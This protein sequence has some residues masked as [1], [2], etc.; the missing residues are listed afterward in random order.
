MKKY[1]KLYDDV[2]NKIKHQILDKQLFPGS[3]IVEER[4]AK[5]EGISRAAVRLVLSRLQEDG[6]VTITPHTGTFV[7]H[8][9]RAEI[10][11]LYDVRLQLEQGVANLAVENITPEAIARMEANYE[12]QQQLIDQYSIKKYARLN[13]DFHWEIIL[14]TQNKF[15]INFLEELYNISQVFL[16]FYDNSVNNSR[17][18]ETHGKILQA[19]HN[20]DK[21][22]LGEM[23][24]L[25]ALSG[26][27]ELDTY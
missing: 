5:E 17:S 16:I 1:E 27:E 11:Q 20:R 18:L 24:K 14:A 9:T 12:A 7:I 10:K 4:L 8:P 2:Y 19:L 23:L 3:H 21:Q 22:M 26:I 15:Y 25:D 6:L 13:R